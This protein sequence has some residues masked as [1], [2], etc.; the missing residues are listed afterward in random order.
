[1]NVGETALK[2]RESRVKTLWGRLKRHK[3]LYL[4]MIPGVLWYVLFHLI[5]LYGIV[6]GFQN[7]TL[8]SE[9]IFS[10]EWVGFDNFRYIFESPDFTQILWNTVYMSLLKMVFGFFAPIILALMINAVTT[11]WYKKIVQTVSYLP[12]FLSWV[13]VF[14]VVD[15]LF[16]NYTGVFKQIFTAL[17]WDYTDPT[18][19][20]SSIIAFLVISAVWKG[21][22][23]SAIIYLASLSG[24]DPQL[25]EAAKVDGASRWEQLLHITVPG[26]LPTCA[27]VLILSVGGILGGDFEQIFLFQGD[28]V[29]IRDMTENF[30]TYSYRVGLQGFQYSKTTALGI[31]QS[32]FGAI[33]IVVTNKLAGKFGYEGIW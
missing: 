1:M 5:P 12:N 9:S 25:Y 26:I 31:F 4:L 23:Y 24:I 8:A 28:N 33:L 21:V 11:G 19:S 13:I 7:Y 15:V 16:N 10:N 2:S 18:T 6:I 27:I 17:G 32:V 30:A 3:Y 29:I 14:S 22:G 20:E